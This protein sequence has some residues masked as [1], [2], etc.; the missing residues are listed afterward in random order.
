MASPD[1]PLLEQLS[2]NSIPYRD[3]LAVLDWRAL[4]L[5]SYWLPPQAVSLHGLDEFEALSDSARM[6]LS[7]FELLAFAQ[8]GIALERLFLEST[9]R[10]LRHAEPDAEYAFLLHELR[11]QA[12]HSLMFLRLAAASGLEVADW[13]RALPPLVRPLGRALRNDVLYWFTMVIAQDVPDKMHRFVRRHAGAETSPFV[14]HM[15]TLQMLD[16]SRHL[17]YARRNLELAM[18]GRGRAL[19][20]VAPGLFDLIFNRF[21]RAYFWPRADVYARAGLGDGR[22]WRHVALRNARRREFVL[23]LVA[24]TMRLLAQQGIRLRLR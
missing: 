5:D 15:M 7:Q 17:A 24:P 13:R 6:R 4:N 8:A 11:E 12:G 9:A 20:R 2:A 23:K 19:V 14:R 22:V 3:P 1:A 21:L 18:Q 16:E 10:R